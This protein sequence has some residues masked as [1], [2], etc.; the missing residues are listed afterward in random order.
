M[1]ALGVVLQMGAAQDAAP[2]PVIRIDVN[3]VQVDAVV[4]DS[5]GRPVPNLTIGDFEVLQDDKPQ[6]VTNLSYVS[7]PQ[8]VV[9]TQANRVPGPEAPPTAALKPADV[10]RTFAMVV[11]DLGL[12]FDSLVHVREAL[13]TFVDQQMQPG[14]LVAIVRTSAGMGAFEQFTGD[15]RLLHAAIDRI[16]FSFLSRAAVYSFAPIVQSDPGEP[17]SMLQQLST[18]SG[19]S[20]SDDVE[21]AMRDDLLRVG[22]LGA[23]R[24]VVEG[25]SE[26]PGR[27]SVVLFSENMDLS[28]LPGT[29]QEVLQTVRGLIDAANRSSVV[30]HTLDPRGVQA[31]FPGASDDVGA[32]G[33]VTAMDQRR[34]KMF[35]TQSGLAVLAQGTG[36]LFIQNDNL[37]DDAIRQV[38]ADSQGYYLI[39]YHPSADTFNGD[40]ANFHSITIRVNRPGLRVHTRSGFFGVADTERAAVPLTREEQLRRVLSSPFS[41]AAIRVQLTALFTDARK[42]DDSGQESPIVRTMLHIDAR[43]LKFADLPGGTHEA[44][45]E[46]LAVTFGDKGQTVGSIDRS[47]SL[48][49]ESRGYPQV[50]ERGLLWSVDSAVKAPGPYQVR[51]AV[52]DAISGEVGSA[53]QFIE[54]PDVNRG[55]LALSSITLGTE[56]GN[57]VD[58]S[59]AVR[60]FRPGE[61]LDYR[62]L[63]FNA[64]SDAKNQPRIQIQ[65]RLFRD[66][67]L[68]YS[69]QAMPLGSADVSEP[70]RI[71]AG[72]Q[73][74]LGAQIAPGDYTLQLIVWDKAVN[75]KAGMAS[76]WMDFEV[77][78]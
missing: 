52:R 44:R 78:P 21:T 15:K 67:T 9:K 10:R 50:L 16:R 47:W 26:L 60:V 27:K 5:K 45:V 61:T 72:G 62:Y 57:G 36:G 19:A 53:S 74:K 68:M 14:D 2:G 32:K 12:S 76:Q 42:Q 41:S 35:D 7:V 59:P 11:D 3:L 28:N 43:D 46:V 54:I 63:I 25:L 24:Y 20:P 71:L 8:S 51:I 39:G 18:A 1:L 13:K 70:K 38:L 49:A 56:A 22:T 6:V 73:M 37:V 69:G 77:K 64:R 58:G 30:I 4:T 34:S 31:F 55:R 65:T 48:D 66:G 29:A 23:I 33:A 17:P 75:G 40:R